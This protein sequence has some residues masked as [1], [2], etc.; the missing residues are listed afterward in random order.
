M[1]RTFRFLFQLR[2]EHYY[3]PLSLP[4]LGSLQDRARQLEMPQYPHVMGMVNFI[5]G[6]RPHHST[7]ALCR[8]PA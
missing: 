4:S 5:L 2:K 1:L 8:P 7:R 3:E 6:S